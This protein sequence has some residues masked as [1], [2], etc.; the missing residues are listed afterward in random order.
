MSYWVRA[1]DIDIMC[2]CKDL[3]NFHENVLL[4]TLGDE[5]YF[6]HYCNPS[7]DNSSIRS[8]Y[9]YYY[10]LVRVASNE[11]VVC[12]VIFNLS[13]K[14]DISLLKHVVYSWQASALFNREGYICWVK[15][16]TSTFEWVVLIRYVIDEIDEI[17]IHTNDIIPMT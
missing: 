1:L 2:D 9:F 8:D 6:P 13:I 17:D 5:Q 7:H 4:I 10:F 3:S 14:I 15:V 11:C 12:I 16:I